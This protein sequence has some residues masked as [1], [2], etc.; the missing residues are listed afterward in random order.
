MLGKN[1][2]QEIHWDSEEGQT[3]QLCMENRPSAS[4][5]WVRPPG[6]SVSWAPRDQWSWGAGSHPVEMQLTFTWSSSV[7]DRDRIG[8]APITESVCGVFVWER[9]RQGRMLYNVKALWDRE[10]HLH[11]QQPD[12]LYCCNVI[13][14]YI[15][16]SK[17]LIRWSLRIH[18]TLHYKLV[19]V[20][21]NVR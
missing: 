18:K 17:R 15:Y 3:T 12:R 10:N 4:G 1:T 9:E 19:L 6:W 16:T 11:L 20:H 8:G 13:Y 2:E 5:E 14:I 7:L 21:L